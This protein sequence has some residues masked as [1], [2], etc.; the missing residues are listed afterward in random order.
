MSFRVRVSLIILFPLI[1]ASCSTQKNTL[2]TRTYHQVTSRYNTYFNGRESFWAGVKR[3]EEQ[4]RYDYN[5]ILPVFLYTDPDIARSIS[6]QMDRTIDKASKVIANK[7]IT[8]K[9]KEGGGLFGS[10]NEE[11]YKQREYN[12]WVR[13]SYLLTGKA[14]FYKHD[15]IP[16][17]QAFLFAIREYSINPVRHEAKI[18]L[19]RTYCERGRFNEAG[20]LFNDMLNDPGFPQGLRGE[21]YSTIADYHLKQDQQEQALINLGRA[22]EA[23]GSKETRA[24]YTYILAQLSERIGDFSQAAEY[25]SRVIRMNPTYEMVFNAHISRAGVFQTGTGET[26][27]MISELER[28]LR[29]EKN[30]DYLDQIYYALGNIYLRN[31]DE[32]NAIRHYKLSA[33]STGIVSSQKAVSYLALAGIYFGYPDYVSAHA[34]YDSAVTNMGHGFPE[35]EAI[36]AKTNVL[37]E[38]ADN[39]R[40]YRL[41]DSVQYLASLDETQLNQTI[42]D[43]IARVREEEAEARQMEQLA[44]QTPQYRSAMAA[45]AS[46]FQSERSGGGNWYFYNPSAI[47][48]GMSEFESLWGGR[49]LEDNWRRSDRQVVSAEQFAF[50]E[51]DDPG[52]EDVEE[53]IYDTKSRDFYMRNIPLTPEALEA[54]HRR[55]QEAL[56]NTGVILRSEMQDYERSVAAYEELVKRYPEGE[57]TLPAYYDLHNVNLLI[58]NY[59]RADYYKDIIVSKYPGSTYAS[60]LTNPDYFREQAEKMREAERYY[61]EIFNLYKEGLFDLVADRASFAIERW[62]ESPLLPRFEYLRTLS[63]GSRG[64]IPLFREMLSG[65][66]A[67]Y[68]GTE[69]AEDAKQFLAYLDDDYPETIRQPEVAISS[70]IYSTRHEGE[71]FLLVV[72]DNNEEQINRIIFNVVS[73]NVDNFPGLDLDVSRVPFSPNIQLVRVSG[74][75]DIKGAM[76]YLKR[77]SASGTVFAE[78]GRDDFT[79]FLI[80][81][82]NY[83]LFLQDKNIPSYLKFFE[84]EYP[85]P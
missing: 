84:E 37:K 2:I 59:Q 41:E 4:F 45:Q 39:I 74:L 20:M 15:F 29:D 13:E 49:R 34:Y 10:R 22:L 67:T 43:I 71:Q 54:S 25:Y 11:F 1:I 78:T 47:A 42:D 16:A 7:S 8:A 12:R 77:F 28:M 50:T 69:M 9:P 19:A 6:P 76:D 38:L 82:E 63:F 21:L 33:A 40:L 81:P 31:G 52:T 65:Y 75:T 79:L 72:A 70:D 3:T 56:F 27:R 51:G 85:F 17:A 30:R 83:D 32:A 46:R 44:R 68:P 66:I 80:S 14:H 64:N 53:E 26:A 5:R 61:E 55:L 35:E 62:P 18:W 60:I 23:T 36:V 24:R 48:F 57:F 73:F 58:M